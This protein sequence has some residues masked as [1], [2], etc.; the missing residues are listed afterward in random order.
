MTTGNVGQD[1]TGC[2]GTVFISIRPCG[3]NEK[4]LN[5]VPVGRRQLVLIRTRTEEVQCLWCPH[6]LRELIGIFDESHFLKTLP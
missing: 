4:D 2:L 5:Q 6:K 3:G 1:G